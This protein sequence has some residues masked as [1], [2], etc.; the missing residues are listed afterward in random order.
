MSV[1]IC[2]ELIRQMKPLCQG[3]HLMT[4][5]WDHLVPD[6]IRSAGLS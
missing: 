5:G 3:A 4:L 1:E 6:I 2:G